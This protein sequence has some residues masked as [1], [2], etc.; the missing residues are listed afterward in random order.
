VELLIVLPPRARH[1][2]HGR[3]KG[4]ADG[5][6][7]TQG[8]EQAVHRATLSP[9]FFLSSPLRS[10]RRKG[11]EDGR[12]RKCIGALRHLVPDSLEKDRMNAD[13]PVIRHDAGSKEL[14]R[15]G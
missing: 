4:G 7:R 15:N 13:I 2:V 6:R 14:F 9:V 10:G 1:A 3:S 5:R 12:G 11:G 8:D